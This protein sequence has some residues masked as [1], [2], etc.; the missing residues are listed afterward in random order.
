VL[1]GRIPAAKALAR[2][3]FH[4]SRDTRKPQHPIA[5]NAATSE[6]QAAS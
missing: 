6:E 3:W 1:V 4:G 2:R 5:A